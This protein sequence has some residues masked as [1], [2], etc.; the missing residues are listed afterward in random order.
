MPKNI[1]LAYDGS[2]SAGRAFEQALDL[3]GKYD[4][5]LTVLAVA[6]PPE[7][8]SEV[9]TEAVIEN[10]RHHCHQLLKP[11]KEMAPDA[12]FEVVVGHPAVK[13]TAWAEEHRIDLIVVGHRG[14]TL[15]ER[16]LIGS[17][18]KKV[19]SYAPCSVLVVR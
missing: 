17:V 15:F 8:G 13:I 19:I 18:A 6:R 11:L 7:F 16:W 3:A 14:K 1:L 2:E 5:K 9:E 4:A 10:S 12:R